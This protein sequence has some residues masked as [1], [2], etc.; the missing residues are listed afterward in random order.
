MKLTHMKRETHW[1]H[2]QWLVVLMLQNSYCMMKFKT[3]L[4]DSVA[5]LG[6]HIQ[7]FLWVLQYS[8]VL[9]L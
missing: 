6:R 8:F 1:I 5:D 9:H 7:T 3:A 4:T 2:L